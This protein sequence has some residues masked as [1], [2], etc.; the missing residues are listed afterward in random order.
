M[1]NDT[2]SAV[3]KLDTA[4]F[5]SGTLTRV[6]IINLNITDATA[7]DHVIITDLNGKT[8]V[9]FTATANELQYRIG[10]IGWVNGVKVGAGNLGT[11]AVV[12][13]AIGAGK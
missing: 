4:P 7:N 1:A 2:T 12:T 8:I 6:K 11:S 5:T 9:D 13:I 10:N 3:W